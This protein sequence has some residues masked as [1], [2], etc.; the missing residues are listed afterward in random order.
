MN[1]QDIDWLKEVFHEAK[2]FS[3]LSEKEVAEVIDHMERVNF[4]RGDIIFKEG[5]EGDWFFIVRYGKVKV[6]RKKA[7]FKEQAVAE[8]GPK[9]F[10]GEM[11]VYE[12]ETR[13]ATLKAVEDT[14]CFVLFKNKF[15]SQTEKHPVF[16]QEIEKLIR[17]R[18]DSQ[19]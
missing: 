9:D 15:K 2:M 10:F 6:V 13:A 14:S 8:L 12:N 11:A 1:A 19:S 17:Q 18:K 3:D 4:S 7:W 16:K 5:D